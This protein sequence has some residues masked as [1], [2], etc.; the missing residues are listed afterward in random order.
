MEAHNKL[1]RDRIPEIIEHEGGGAK[2]RTLSDEEYKQELLIK[3]VE[4]AREA[5]ESKGDNKEL[6]K[7]IGDVLE[8]IDYLIKVFGLDEKEI[9]RTKKERKQSRGGFDK[10][11]F[12]EYVVRT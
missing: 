7:E 8:V 3:L 10:K 9:K 2:I 12:L 4:E 11:L 1:I 5:L 6:T